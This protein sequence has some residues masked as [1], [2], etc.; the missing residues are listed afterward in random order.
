MGRL[1]YEEMSNVDAALRLILGLARWAPKKAKHVITVKWRA[2]SH[3]RTK[4][5]RSR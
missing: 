4:G 1:T 2:T 3:S 5:I